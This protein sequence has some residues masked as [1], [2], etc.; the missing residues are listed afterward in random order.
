[1][2]DWQPGLHDFTEKYQWKTLGENCPICNSLNGRVHTLDTWVSS[3]FYPGFHPNCDCYLQHMDSDTRESD[4]DIFGSNL[5]LYT[6]KW[7]SFFSGQWKTLAWF[8]TDE[9]MRASDPG[10][11]ISDAF[12]RLRAGGIDD[13]IAPYPYLGSW[14]RWQPSARGTASLFGRST[15]WFYS[16]RFPANRVWLFVNMFESITGRYTS[17]WGLHP[18]P[19]RIEPEDPVVSYSNPFYLSIVDVIH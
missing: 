17:Q 19:E 18:R 16:L 9:F 11:T 10:A 13:G 1:M 5:Q 3:G 14:Y 8:L 6:S 2:S 15:G 7:G 4:P 12:S